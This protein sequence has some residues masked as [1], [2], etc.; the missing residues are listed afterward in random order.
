M[1]FEKEDEKVFESVRYDPMSDLLETNNAVVTLD[2]FFEDDVQ[3]AQ[4]NDWEKH[5]IGMPEFQNKENKYFHTLKIHFKNQEDYDAF[6]KLIEQ[7]LTLKTKSTWY[8]EQDRLKPSDY[9]WVSED[10]IDT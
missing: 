8:P 6:A 9:A 1:K 7:N 5:W 10:D 3:E 2:S 4:T